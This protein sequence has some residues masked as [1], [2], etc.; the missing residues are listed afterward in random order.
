MRNLMFT[1][2]GASKIVAGE[3]TMTARHWLIK[4]PKKGSLVSAACGY[5]TDDRFAILKITDV[6]EWDGEWDGEDAYYVTGL[7]IAEIAKREGYESWEEFIEAY[8]SFQ[9]AGRPGKRHH[10]LIGFEVKEILK[11]GSK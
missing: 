1:S 6:W 5:Q 2:E 3:K 10:Y 9:G 8:Q 11:G 4:P 7:P